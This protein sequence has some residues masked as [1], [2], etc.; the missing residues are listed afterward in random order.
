[1]D[2]ELKVFLKRLRYYI[3]IGV[4]TRQQVK[5]LRGQ[6]IH[7]DLSGAEKGLERLRGEKL[8]GGNQ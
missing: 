4:L 3:Q 7:G 2:N 5:T 1:M 8:K 6:A